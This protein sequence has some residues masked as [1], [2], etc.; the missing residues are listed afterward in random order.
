MALK[1]NHI[2]AFAFVMVMLAVPFTAI[3]LQ[4]EYSEAMSP[5]VLSST[6]NTSPTDP[7]IALVSI[8]QGWERWY[9]DASKSFNALGYDW[10]LDGM[11]VGHEVTVVLESLPAGTHTIALKVINGYGKTSTDTVTVTVPSAIIKTTEIENGKWR[12]DAI[13]STY[14][15]SYAWILDGK[16]VGNAISYETGNLSLGAHSVVLNVTSS[17][18]H[19]DTDSTWVTVDDSD[20]NS[21]KDDDKSWF[22]QYW[23]IVI[24]LIFVVIMV[25]RFW[26]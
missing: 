20:A 26:L 19:T 22:E 4:D 9:L 2:V 14:A 13:G 12:F 15:T 17:T 11:V 8:T 23:W 1:H 25:V 6:G 5:A 18:G 3:Q 24:I 16:S 21:D 10:L 7:P